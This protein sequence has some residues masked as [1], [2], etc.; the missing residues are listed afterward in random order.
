M[1]AQKGVWPIPQGPSEKGWVI[2]SCDT[3]DKVFLGGQM[4]IWTTI[5]AC[6]EP[7]SS[8]QQTDTAGTEET[9][10]LPPLELIQW[11][12]GDPTDQSGLSTQPGLILMGGGAEPDAAF[13]WWLPKIAGGD[14]VVLRV[15]GED[16]YN[17]YLYEDI[18]GIDS[19]QTLKVD[20]RSLAEDP[21]VAWQIEHAEGVFI[22]GGDQWDSLSLWSGTPL[23]DA[24]N[25]LLLRGLS[26][27]GPVLVWP[28]WVTGPFQLKME[29]STVKKPWPIPSTLT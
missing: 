22:A 10:P 7:N 19:I 2:P 26:L 23:E 16:G 13:Q 1:K 6:S 14:V 17:D 12:S 11:T 21:Y 25:G 8:K 28:F 18:G 9:P 24:L 15:S 29:P 5:L 3:I 20:S 4:W 27:G